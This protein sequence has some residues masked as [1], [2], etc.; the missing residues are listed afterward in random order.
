MS[1]IIPAPLAV[2]ATRTLAQSALPDAP[3][4]PEDVRTPSRAIAFLRT[5][6]RWATRPV[7]RRPNRQHTPSPAC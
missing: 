3:V 7:A 4:E 2:Q 1:F 5:L 6:F